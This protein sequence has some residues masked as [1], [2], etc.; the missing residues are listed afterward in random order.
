MTTVV[1]YVTMVSR[2]SN[3]ISDL[4][5]RDFRKWWNVKLLPVSRFECQLC[6]RLV[7]LF[8]CQFAVFGGSRE[9][10][11]HVWHMMKYPRWTR[12]EP[13][14][15]LTLPYELLVHDGWKFPTDFQFLTR[16]Q[17]GGYILQ[18]RIFCLNFCL[19]SKLSHCIITNSTWASGCTYFFNFKIKV[20]M[21]AIAHSE[22][23]LWVALFF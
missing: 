6:Y 15:V 12:I 11:R 3:A 23:N 2:P 22:T 21:L 10:F 13:I 20:E 4:A 9:L 19:R 5:N 16:F 1:G 14:V 7:S 17:S 8:L 18:L